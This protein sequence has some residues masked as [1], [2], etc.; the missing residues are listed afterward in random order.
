MM[1][2]RLRRFSMKRIRID[3][4]TKK[5]PPF[6]INKGISQDSKEFLIDLLKNEY[7]KYKGDDNDKQ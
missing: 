5:V 7:Y 1:M 2:N 4:G 6:T 3:L